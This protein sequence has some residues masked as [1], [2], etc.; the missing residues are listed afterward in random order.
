MQTREFVET[1]CTKYV[2]HTSHFLWF[3][4]NKQLYAQVEKVMSF[5]LPS[6]ENKVFKKSA[7]F[8]ISFGSSTSTKHEFQSEKT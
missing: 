1:S 3:P 8:L 6:L 7:N 4:K 5:T 2:G